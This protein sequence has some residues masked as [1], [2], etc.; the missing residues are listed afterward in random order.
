[1]PVC[2]CND[3]HSCQMNDRRFETIFILI[4]F[5]LQA[6]Q[7]VNDR[8]LEKN[9]A[10]SLLFDVILMTTDGQQQQQSS[11]IISSTRHHGNFIL[12]TISSTEHYGDLTLTLRVQITVSHRSVLE[13]VVLFTVV[14]TSCHDVTTTLLQVLKLAGSVFLVRKISLR[15]YSKITCR[16]S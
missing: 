9:P 16:C 4:Y 8:L 3:I 7:R 1:M 12:I 15:V 5:I 11:R 6:L 10:E 2:T 13:F 14:S